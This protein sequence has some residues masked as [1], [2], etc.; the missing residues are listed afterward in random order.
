M[1]CAREL[2]QG[3]DRAGGE[4]QAPRREAP[5]AIGQLWAARRR[6]GNCDRGEGRG[7]D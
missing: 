6:K 3:R 7:A 2:R 1:Q 4:S 5:E